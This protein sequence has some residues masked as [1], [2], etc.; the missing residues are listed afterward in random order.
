MNW[1]DANAWAESLTYGGYT[2][3]RLPYIVDT[4]SVGCNYAVS[5]TDC[6]YNVQTVSGGYVYSEMAYM[7]YVNLGLKGFRLPDRSFTD[8]YGIFRNGTVGGQNNVGLINNLQSDEYWSSTLD[9]T[10]YQL[11]FAWGFGTADGFQYG[12]R[13]K[14]YESYAWAVRDG[15]VTFVPS[16]SVPEPTTM[17]L[18]GLGMG[19]AVL[20]RRQPV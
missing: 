19:M 12:G 15:D 9:Q 18:L 6:G 17:L 8:D 13:D 5:G 2:G 14:G 20:R 1:D 3:W 4:N 16:S 11:W 10:W 7:Y